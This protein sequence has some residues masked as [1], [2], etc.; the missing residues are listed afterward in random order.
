MINADFVWIGDDGNKFCQHLIWQSVQRGVNVFSAS[1][2]R[3]GFVAFGL[4]AASEILLLPFLR[5]PSWSRW[6]RTR[7]RARTSL[8]VQRMGVKDP[9]V[10]FHLVYWLFQWFQPKPGWWLQSSHSNW[11]SLQPE[12]MTKVLWIE[13]LCK[14]ARFYSWAVWTCS[15][16][17]ASLSSDQCRRVG[18]LPSIIT[19]RSENVSLESSARSLWTRLTCTSSQ[20]GDLLDSQSDKYKLNAVLMMEYLGLLL[21]NVK[22]NPPF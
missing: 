12:M 3:C 13:P 15:S 22:E 18:L 4:V 19:V 14:G 5:V 1:T 21:E 20:Y 6:R 10:I 11:G 7:W 16:A 8:W 9:E 2:T 17:T